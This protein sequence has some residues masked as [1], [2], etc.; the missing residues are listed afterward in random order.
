MSSGRAS[1]LIGRDEKEG[2][3]MRK[4]MAGEFMTVDGVCEAPDKWSMQFFNDEVGAIIGANMARSDAMLMGRRTY[5]EWAAYWP[6][7]TVED[8]QFA[9]YINNVQKYVVSTTLT[10]VDW[11]GAALLSGD[12]R[13]EI[14]KLKEQPGK[15]IAI[16]GS[17]TLV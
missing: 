16:S 3:A 17:I 6:G 4:I 1:G 13:E 14:T 2:V 8:D 12:F 7:K 15:D 10:S 11:K 5:E 9:D